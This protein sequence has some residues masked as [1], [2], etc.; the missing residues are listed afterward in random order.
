METTMI[1]I[2][3]HTP[4][5]GG[6]GL[7][8][9]IGHGGFTMLMNCAPRIGVGVYVGSRAALF[10]GVGGSSVPIGRRLLT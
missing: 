3:S 2:M 5:L 4:Y 6:A 10:A 7:A 1:Q 8:A 9:P